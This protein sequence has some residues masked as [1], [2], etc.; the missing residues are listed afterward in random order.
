[1]RRSVDSVIAKPPPMQ[2]PRIM[3]M[4]G[5]NAALRAACAALPASS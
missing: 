5:F 2:M 1:M 4:V 3:E